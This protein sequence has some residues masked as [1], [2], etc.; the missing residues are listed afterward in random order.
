[1]TAAHPTILEYPH[2]APP[3]P[4]ATLEVVPGVHWL[5]M[6]L[7]FAL[8]HINLWLLDEGDAWTLID[9][10]YGDAPTRALW[11]RHFATTMRGL[12]LREIV[13]T[14][15]HPDHLGNAAWLA[16]RF[17]SPVRMTHT[18]FLAAHAILTETAAHG[19]L[20][21]CALF[22]THGMPDAEVAAMAALGNRYANGVPTAPPSVR[23]LLAGDHVVAGGHTWQVLTGYG[24]SPEHASL[25]MQALDVLVSGD[26]LLP[27]ITTNVSVWPSDPDGDPLGRFLASIAE[28]ESLSPAALVLPSHGLP[29]RGIPLRVE[30]LRVHHAARLAELRDAV[31]AAGTPVSA[32]QMVPFLFRRPL[33]LH[34]RFFAMGEAIAHL[35]HLWH[36]GRLSRTLSPEGQVRFAI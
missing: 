25:Y 28:F 3:A 27:K 6:P 12:P 22:R 30:A 9:T 2:A 10:G 14:H 31:A 36:R 16:E 34:Q 32:L 7:P 29:F 35:N 26:M 19:P 11:E 18:E 21:T 17:A 4:G 33:D 8:D 20:D 15:C 5:R 13:V 1:M 24:H 23:R